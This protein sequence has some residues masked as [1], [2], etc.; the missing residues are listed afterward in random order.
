MLYDNKYYDK[1]ILALCDK[2]SLGSYFRLVGR[3]KFVY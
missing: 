2:E 1:N 3:E